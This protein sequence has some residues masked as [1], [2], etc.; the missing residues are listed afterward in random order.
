[1]P[2]LSR[3]PFDSYSLPLPRRR[4]GPATAL[5]FAA[6][7]IIAILVLWRGAELLEAGGGGGGTGPRGGGGGGGRPVVSWFALPPAEPPATHE[8]SPAPPPTVT[9]PTAAPPVTEP[10]KL[11]VLAPPVA[12]APPAA[13][14]T[15]NG[16]AGGPGEGPGSGGGKGT[17]AGS[18]VG[19]DSG[20][21]SGGP[22][23]DIF[24][25]TPLW[26]IMAPPGAPRDAHGKAHE[27]RFWVM[28]DGR[29]SRVEVTP[30]IKDAGYRRE[31]MERMMGYL[32]RPATTRDGR[33]VESVASLTVYP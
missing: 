32:F 4:E 15:G 2:D 27:V 21:G 11:V 20:S 5:S 26:A 16:T 7:V 23:S 33:H 14:G 1:M 30:P 3:P 12:L 6:H 22:A 25:A 8:V 29:V 28:A 24:G 10:I 18:G 13:V 31:F 9:V 17:G 19:A